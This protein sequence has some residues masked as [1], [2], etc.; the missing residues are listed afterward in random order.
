M[1]SLKWGKIKLKIQWLILVTQFLKPIFKLYLQLFQLFKSTT[2][3]QKFFYSTSREKQFKSLNHFTSEFSSRLRESKTFFICRRVKSKSVLWRELHWFQAPRITTK[4]IKLH[5]R[6][7]LRAPSTW[8]AAARGL[9][10]VQGQPGFTVSK[11]PVST[12][13]WDQKTKSV[14]KKTKQ[15]LLSNKGI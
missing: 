10:E 1:N 12:A 4:L 5:T 13:W 6:L 7:H 9:P 14:T 15:T 8:E 11:R 2:L 3:H